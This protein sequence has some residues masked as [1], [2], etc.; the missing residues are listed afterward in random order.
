M[1][2][3]LTEEQI[4]R[5]KKIFSQFDK[6]GSGK[7]TTQELRTL[8]KELGQEVKGSEAQRMI[9]EIDA[10]GSGTI[11]FPEFLVLLARV[12]DD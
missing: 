12:N 7:I 2:D 8:L 11:E 6:D 3:Q 1:A 4:A 5:Y 10:N 9:D